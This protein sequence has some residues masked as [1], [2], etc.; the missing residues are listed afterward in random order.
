M[1]VFCIN[2]FND[3]LPIKWSERSGK[4]VYR[5]SYRF[6]SKERNVIYSEKQISHIY[7]FYHF[8]ISC[9]LWLRKGRRSC[10]LLHDISH[11]VAAIINRI[12]SSARRSDTQ[13]WK[14]ANKI[15]V[16]ARALLCNPWFGFVKPTLCIGYNKNVQKQNYVHTIR[17]LVVYCS[18]MFVI[19][20]RRARFWSRMF[21]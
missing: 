1:H 14:K 18:E 8:N 13:K 12:A 11:I 10:A 9:V 7:L 6:V 21:G 4:S 17:T 3:N 5:Y 19:V 20:W 15:I 16:C 2:A